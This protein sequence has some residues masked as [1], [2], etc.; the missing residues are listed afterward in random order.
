MNIGILTVTDPALR[1][2]QADGA[3]NG[4]AK[5]VESEAA[6]AATPVAPPKPR[7]TGNIAPSVKFASLRAALDCRIAADVSSGMLVESDAGTVRQTLDDIDT[8]STAA[9][10]PRAAR[11]YLATIEPGTL[12]DR[13][14]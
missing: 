14:G 8:R 13:L 6:E 11:A 7:P 2:L 9:N 1:K 10:P 12:I 5:P 3:S 4:K